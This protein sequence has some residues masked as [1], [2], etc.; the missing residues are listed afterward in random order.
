D[1]WEAFQCLADLPHPLFLDSALVH[2]NL[3]RYSFL[4]A[5]PFEWLWSRGRQ[6]YLSGRPRPPESAEPFAVLAECLA[7]YRAEP[8]PGLP[9]FQG[10]AAGLFGY[11]LCH[12]LER[13]PRPRCDEF[14]VPDLAVGFYDWVLAFDH[15]A[16][17]AWIIATGIPESEPRRRRLRAERRL[18]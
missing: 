17:R 6:V 5:D 15:V 7:R 3:G 2:A 13:L 12:H 16:G 11:D 9:P 14:Q 18:H 4:T 1:A 10:G 8:L